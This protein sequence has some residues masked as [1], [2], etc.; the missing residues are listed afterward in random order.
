MLSFREI[1]DCEGYYY[2]P[3]T[4]DLVRVVGPGTDRCWAEGSADETAA[5][6]DADEPQFELVTADMMTPIEAVR[7]EVTRRYPG[8]SPGRLLHRQTAAQPDGRLLTQEAPIRLPG[9]PG[10]GPPSD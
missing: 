7:R 3:K 5:V 6:A 1:Q 10:A 8:A 4:G 9:S 2:S